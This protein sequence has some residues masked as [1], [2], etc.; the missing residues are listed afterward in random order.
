MI[1]KLLLVTC[2]A[3]QFFASD[4]WPTVCSAVAVWLRRL[5]SPRSRA[6]SRVP[7]LQLLVPVSLPYRIAA[8]RDWRA[9][10]CSRC[11]R[12][13]AR[14]WMRGETAAARVWRADVKQQHWMK[15]R[16]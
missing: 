16:W 5:V 11:A 6:D 15:V 9:V 10:D 12:P 8:S 4:S 14:E 7:S 1:A 2:F 3:F 13:V